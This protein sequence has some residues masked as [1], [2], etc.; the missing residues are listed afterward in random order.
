MIVMKCFKKGCF[1]FLAVL[2]SVFFSCGYGAYQVLDHGESVEEREDALKDF[3][4]PEVSGS[5]YSFLIITDVHFGKPKTRR[6]STFLSVLQAKI[7]SGEISPAPSFG[8][9]LGDIADHGERSEYVDYNRFLVNVEGILGGKVYSI[10]GNHDL[11]NNGWDDFEDLVYPNTSFY[12]FVINNIS[13]YFLDSGSGSLGKEQ[14]NRF[15]SAMTSDPN[16]KIV[17]SHYTVYGTSDFFQSYYSTQNTL[18]AD[19]LITILKKNRAIA[20]IAGHMHANHHTNFGTFTEYV[21]PAYLSNESFAVMTVDE[22]NHSA[23][24]K[25]YS[26]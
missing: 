26:Y 12:R 14:F 10:I 18:E 5:R 21:V 3:P 22:S 8:V 16:Y 24:Y 25:V 6:D 20:H 11:Y 23:S 13:Y 1:L 2:M 15:K 19:Q 4:A 17:C 9:C 7:A